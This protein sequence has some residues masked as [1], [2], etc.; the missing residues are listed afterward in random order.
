MATIIP[1]MAQK[2]VNVA[3]VENRGRIADM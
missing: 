2:T 1:A 3:A